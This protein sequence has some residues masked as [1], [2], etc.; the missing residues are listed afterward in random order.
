MRGMIISSA[1]SPGI[2]R[3]VVFLLSEEAKYVTG[4]TF[5]VDGG[6]CAQ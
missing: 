5:P 1:L 2:G 3:P 6:V 4:Q